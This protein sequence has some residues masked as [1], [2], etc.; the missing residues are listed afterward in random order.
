MKTFAQW[1]DSKKSLTEFL[2]I[3]EEVEQEIVDYF[4]E[5]LPPV[6]WTSTIVQCGEPYDSFGK[7]GAYRYIT[8][9]KVSKLWFYTGKKEGMNK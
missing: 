5:V 9:E 4:I 8:F 2:N 3:G 6:T 7:N 1:H